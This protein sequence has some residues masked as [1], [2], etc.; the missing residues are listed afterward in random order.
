M[1]KATSEK[2]LLKETTEKKVEGICQDESEPKDTKNKQIDVPLVVVLGP[3]SGNP[4]D[5]VLQQNE[6]KDLSQ[7]KEKTTMTI[8]FT[9][10][11]KK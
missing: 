10:T 8:D 11:Q 5:N 4:T 6:T 1:I 9:L 7:G 2:G 3:Y